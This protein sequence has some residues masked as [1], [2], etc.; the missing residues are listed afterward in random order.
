MNKNGFTPTPERESFF[1]CVPD[2]N[3]RLVWGFTIVEILVTLS[4]I[5]LL[6]GILIIYGRGSEKQLLLFRDQAKIVNAILKA[7]SLAL[8]TYSKD[9]SP[10]AYGVHFDAVKKEFR[11]FKDLD[12]SGLNL[13]CPTADKIYSSSPSPNSEDL[14]PPIVETL[15][16]NLSFKLPLTATD[17]VFIPPDINAIITPDP[18]PQTQITMEITNPEGISKK[19]KINVFGQISAE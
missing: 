2:T 6:S 16:Q 1:S 18:S 9:G 19:I 4:I 17:I 12:S 14:N 3:S 15:G 10:C 13:D 5:A 7:K 8:N 11:I